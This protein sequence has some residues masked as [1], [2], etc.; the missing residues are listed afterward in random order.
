MARVAALVVLASAS[1]ACLVTTLHPAYDDG[2]RI[3]DERLIGQWENGEDRT[4]ATIERAEWRSYKVTYI[5]RSTTTT[6]HGN[7]TRVGEALFLDLTQS[8][9]VDAGP[10]LLPVHGVYRIAFSGDALSVAGLD[11][12]WFSRTLTAKKLARLAATLDGR[13]NVLL[14]AT[15]GELR[16]WLA[17]AP[18]E[19][20]AAAMTFSRSP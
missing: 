1:S 14:A 15:T 10:Y 18:D 6:F 11:Y 5:D 16:A 17:Q 12:V 3:F 19:A 2:S 4:S 7:L 20:F 8:H 13:R 9:G